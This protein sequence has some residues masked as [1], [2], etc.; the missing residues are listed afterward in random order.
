MTIEYGGGYWD[1]NLLLNGGSTSRVTI[2]VTD[3]T[4]QDSATWGVYVNRYVNV[5]A[6]LETA[7]A[8]FAYAGI[9]VIGV[10]SIPAL[11][12]WRRVRRHR[13]AVAPR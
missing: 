13:K 6:D 3:C 12:V 4:F 8:F 1:A 10:V 2:A 5:N 9:V 7:N 11:L